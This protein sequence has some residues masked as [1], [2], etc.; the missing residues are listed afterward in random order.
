MYVVMNL[1]NFTRSVDRLDAFTYGYYTF[2]FTTALFG[3]KH[4]IS[5]YFGLIDTPYLVSSYNTYTSFWTFY[6]DFGVPG[7]AVIPALLGWGISS[8]Y[9][10]MRT[11]PNLR[12]LTFYSV[13]VFVMFIS[14]FNSPL[15]FLWFVYN[16]LVVYI[17]LRVI[18]VRPNPGVITSTGLAP[19]GV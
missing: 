3:L 13:A 18:R 14:F 15:G 17:I 4:W 12:S 1:E 11:N 19:A 9:Y 16:M 7:V 2:D 5:D 10:W 8:S 6:R